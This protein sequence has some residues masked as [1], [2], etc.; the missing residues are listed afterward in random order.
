MCG[1]C[2]SACPTGIPLVEMYAGINKRIQ[3]LF[4]YESGR[5]VEEPQPFTEFRED[6]EFT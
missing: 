1:Q 4:G 6:E 3:D 2:E 5:S